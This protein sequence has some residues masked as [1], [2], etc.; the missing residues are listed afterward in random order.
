[1]RF[2]RSISSVIYCTGS[3]PKFLPVRLRPVAFT[4]CMRFLCESC[5]MCSCA[6]RF[7][8]CMGL[9]FMVGL[10]V[11]SWCHQLWGWA[12]TSPF[13]RRAGRRFSQL[14]AS[15]L[16]SWICAAPLSVS[17]LIGSQT[18]STPASSVSRPIFPFVS[19][20]DQVS[21]VFVFPSVVG[22]GIEFC[23]VFVFLLGVH[24]SL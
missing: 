8:Y 7:I 3:Q 10:I 19:G 11:F 9:S 17:V 4:L 23:L 14:S 12:A 15:S 20:Q 22:A 5:R 16:T 1:M 13:S 21:L 24:V 18:A 6:V 2:I